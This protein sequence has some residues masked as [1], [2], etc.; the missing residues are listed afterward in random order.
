MCSTARQCSDNNCSIEKALTPLH[1][2]SLHQACTVKSW[3]AWGTLE[4]FFSHRLNVFF[5]GPVLR[6]ILS[7]F[8]RSWCILRDFATLNRLVCSDLRYSVPLSCKSGV[9][10]N[11]IGE[12]NPILWINIPN[13]PKCE[14]SAQV[15]QTS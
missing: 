13:R 3:S 1:R 14:V 9:L 6:F 8:D 5:L 7:D 10:V 11:I 2:T 15:D 12:L 4:K